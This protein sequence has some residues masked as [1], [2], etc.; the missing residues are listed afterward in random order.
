[1]DRNELPLEPRHLGVP[2][3]ASKMIYGPMVRLPQT[4][5]LYCPDTNTLSKW[6]NK[7]FH[8]THSPRCSI[9]CVHDD[10]WADGT[11]SANHTPILNQDYYYLQTNLDKLPLE[12]WHLGV[13]LG[14]SKTISEP[15]VRSAQTVHLYCTNN[16][17]VSKQTETRFHITHVT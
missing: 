12:P 3:R 9:G 15:M 14:A 4:V 17:T 13:S 10:F 5:H 8:M 7:R 11:F 16:N 2:L 6:T 1:M